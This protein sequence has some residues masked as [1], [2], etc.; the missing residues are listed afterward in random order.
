LPRIT[1]FDGCTTLRITSKG[2]VTVPV[3]IRRQAGLFPDTEVEFAVADGHVV[4][5][6]TN[7]ESSGRGSGLVQSLRG[8]ANT[9]WTTDEI[10]ALTRSED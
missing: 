3:E 4:L 6:K 2:Q 5:R 9:D 1:S 7:S 10:M 8:R